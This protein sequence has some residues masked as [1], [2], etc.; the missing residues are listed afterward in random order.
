MST[1]FSIDRDDVVRTF[2]RT[3]VSTVCSALASVQQL[4]DNQVA[5]LDRLLET[6]FATFR[7]ATSAPS[8][9]ISEWVLEANKIFLVSQELKKS[10][11]DIYRP[12]PYS[13][14]STANK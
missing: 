11:A 13:L 3:Q 14:G 10:G 7:A 6:V 8:A 5:H 1:V 2:F 12:A 9:N 4:A